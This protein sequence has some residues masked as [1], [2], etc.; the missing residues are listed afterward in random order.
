MQ[1]AVL[2]VTWNRLETTQQSFSSIKKAK[3]PRLYIASD[4]HRDGKEGE[5]EIINNV[6][7]WIL[8]N[9]DWDCEVKTRFLEKNSGGCAKG[10]SE[11]VTW[12]FNEEK[13]GI[14]LEDDCVASA[15]FFSFCEELLNRYRDDKRVWSI[16]GEGN[17]EDQK[18]KTSYYFA[19][20]P[21]C[22]GWATWADRWKQFKFDLS[23]YKEKNINFFQKMK[24][25]KN[26]GE[27]F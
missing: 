9:I 4:G 22:W 15:S 12:F 17:Y 18:A 20:I 26:F 14:I 6:R 10:V 21:H 5:R 3:P 23:D 13:E 7:E 2:F 27:I 11:A 19:K 24:I 1:K 25:F 16:T 8:S